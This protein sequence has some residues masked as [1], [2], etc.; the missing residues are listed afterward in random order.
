MI[1]SNGT[2]G[3]FLTV[4]VENV[5]DSAG[6]N[7]TGSLVCDIN[8]GIQP[9]IFIVSV[10]GGKGTRDLQATVAGVWDFNA[11]FLDDF[12]ETHYISETK[13]VKVLV[14]K[15][16]SNLA[17]AYADDKLTVTLDG[18]NGEKLNETVY[19][20]IDDN[21]QEIT[22]SNGVYECDLSN[23]ATGSHAAYAVFKGNNNYLTSSDYLYFS[24]LSPVLNTSITVTVNNISYGEKAVIN[25]TFIDSEGIKLN[26][27]LNVTVEDKAQEVD[28]TDGVGSLEIENLSADTYPIVASFQ[29]NATHSSSI[30]TNYFVVAK[31]ATLIEFENMNTIAVAPVEGKTGEWFY[32]TLKDANGKAIANAPMQIGF[33]GVVYTY[34]KDGICTDENGTAKLQINLGY[35]GDYTFAI[36]FLGNENYNA[37]FAVAKIH[38]DVQKPSLTVPNKSYKASAKTKTLTASFKSA[39]GKVIAGKWISFTVNGKTYNAKTNDKG[40]AS[41][42][43]SISKAGTYKVTAKYAGDS[44]YAAVNK[45]ANLVIK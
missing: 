36:C 30:G 2:Y 32:F 26:G 35:K 31:N 13:G 45:T 5:T 33:N 41:L 21:Q 12:V 11:H 17:L 37:S 23:L 20:T 1:V 42:N 34:E 22:T 43:L 38:V 40:V 25:F 27:K 10:Q 7:L 6:N 39:V 9:M 14:E 15:A 24:T 44:T 19:L 18:I 3:D 29:G 8:D 28:I 4:T 16:N